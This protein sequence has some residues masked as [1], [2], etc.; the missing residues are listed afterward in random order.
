MAAS[1]L[2]AAEPSQTTRREGDS[3]IIEVKRS[4]EIPD[5]IAPAVIPYVDCLSNRTRE[6]Q[7]TGRFLSDGREV[8]DAVRA[9]CAFERDEAIF[10][11]STI[12]ERMNYRDIDARRKSIF[13]ALVTVEKFM[14]VPPE[15]N[16]PNR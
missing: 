6:V 14:L 9:K 10:M 16:A 8:Q 11:A 4:F 5:E 13:D 1:G 3:T 7:E 12:L 2:Q 15:I